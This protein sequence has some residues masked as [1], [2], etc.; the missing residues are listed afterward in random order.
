MWNVLKQKRKH[1]I[2][3]SWVSLE[4][5]VIRYEYILNIHTNRK[6]VNI[7]FIL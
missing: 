2:L 5:M 7:T 1:V 3:V 6:Y 4:S